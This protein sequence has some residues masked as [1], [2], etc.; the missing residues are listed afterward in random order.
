MHTFFYGEVDSISE[1][2]SFR[3]HAEWRSVLRRCFSL[4]SWYA[5][6]ALGNLKLFLR[7][8][9]AGSCDD[10]GSVLCEVPGL[11]CSQAETGENEGTGIG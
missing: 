10:G 7:S 2:L 4:Q 1:V 5:M 3:S 6:L 9:V 8:S 11:G